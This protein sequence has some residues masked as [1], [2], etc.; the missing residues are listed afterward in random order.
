MSSGAAAPLHDGAGPALALARQTLLHGWTHALFVWA[1][2]LGVLALSAGWFFGSV[3]FGGQQQ[4]VLVTGA[5]LLRLALAV[6]VAV[7]CVAAI[8]SDLAERWVEMLLGAGLA[9][10]QWVCGRLG[11][12]ALLALGI[13][14]CAATPLTL[15][16]VLGTATGGGG[17]GA[18]WWGA[19]LALEMAL[20]AAASV[21]AA[22]SLAG[23]AVPVVAVLAFYGLSRSMDAL[24][25]MAATTPGDGGWWADLT[26]WIV[27]GLSWLLPRLDSFAPSAWL[28]GT[29]TPAS[30]AAV[31]GSMAHV[32]V[33]MLLLGAVALVDAYRRRF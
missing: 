19:S 31:A 32:L 22:L 4:A 13:S 23:L 20:L 17:A 7:T 12:C 25:A 1:L 16:A 10:W 2:G 3:A 11:A 8:Q 18:L 33:Y 5:A 9:R 26:L 28:A 6:F 30:A 21:A 24:L 27:R 14:V 15:W 29:G